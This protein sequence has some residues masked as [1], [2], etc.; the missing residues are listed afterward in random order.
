MLLVGTPVGDAHRHSQVGI[1]TWGRCLL[2]L[3]GQT[4]DKLCHLLSTFCSR[5]V[6]RTSL[7]YVFV[8][9]CSIKCCLFSRDQGWVLL[10]QHHLHKKQ[11]PSCIYI[12]VFDLMPFL[13]SFSG[14]HQHKGFPPPPLFQCL[15][16]F[17][18]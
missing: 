17:F 7:V 13:S 18:P 2:C 11:V 5:S 9:L 4:T 12:A 8:F 15:A 3:G 14:W 16:F 10:C 6:Y 1:Y